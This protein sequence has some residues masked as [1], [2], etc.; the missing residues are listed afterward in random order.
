MANPETGEACGVQRTPLTPDARK[1][2]IGRAMLGKAGAVMLSPDHAVE[3]GLGVTEG[4]E[5]A[6]AVL[7]AGW[8]PVWAC[9]SAGMI[10]RLPALPGIEAITVFADADA[11]GLAAAE[12]CAARWREAGRETRIIRPGRMGADFAD[13]FAGGAP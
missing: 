2:P 6:F 11:A 7:A 12:T 8:R 1:H 13:V 3:T 9:L 5:T 10:A 4:V